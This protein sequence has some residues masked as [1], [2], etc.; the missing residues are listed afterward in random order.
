MVKDRIDQG[1]DGFLV[2]TVKALVST[3]G[4]ASADIGP[5]GVPN[6]QRG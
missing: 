2:G 3:M 1:V 4:K 5:V 6:L